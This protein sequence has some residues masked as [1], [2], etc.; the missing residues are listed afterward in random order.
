MSFKIPFERVGAVFYSSSIVTMAVS[1]TV[2]TSK[3]YS[4]H[5]ATRR[6]KNFEDMCNGNRFHTIA[7][8]DGQTDRH[9]ATA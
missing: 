6:C 7:A 5:G 1:L 2:Y 8:C 3:K 4:V 9:L